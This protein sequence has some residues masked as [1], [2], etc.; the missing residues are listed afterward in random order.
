MKLS[1]I[2]LA[3][4]M[5]VS[6]P[7]L[8]EKKQVSSA[9][10]EFEV[11]TGWKATGKGDAKEGVLVAVSPDQ[12]ASIIFAVSE[13]ENMEKAI[14]ALDAMLGK[15]VINA[16]T[17]K[18]GKVTVNGM[19]GLAAKGAAQVKVKDKAIDV[20]TAV[21]ILKTK[22]NKILFV[23]GIVNAAKKDA[24]KA[25]FDEVIKSIKPQP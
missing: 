6:M 23:I 24:Y 17:A 11:P 13:A 15:V 8:A 25:T 14:K 20:K 3:V 12:E 22:A 4:V 18:A 19:E 16:K 5:A 9:K 7:A 1:L 10:V 2:A 21:L